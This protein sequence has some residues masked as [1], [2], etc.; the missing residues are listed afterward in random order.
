[1]AL[2]RRRLLAGALAAPVPAATGCAGTVV[3]PG[4]LSRLRIMAPASLGGGW[5]TT[6]RLLQ[7]VIRSTGIARSVQLFNVEGAGGT[8]GLGQLSRETDDALLYAGILLFASL[9]SYAVNADPLDLVLLLILGLLGFAMRRFGWPVAPAVIGLI[10]GPVAET[11]LRRA[12]AIGEGNPMALVSSPLAVFV[13]VVAL[14]V[15]VLPPLLR[16]R[17][18]RQQARDEVSAG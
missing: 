1:M 5:D 15:I 6:A 2:T 18:D 11:S 8:I 4:D 13:Y 3:R 14:L 17:R 10:L 9:G 12:I 7:R 16:R